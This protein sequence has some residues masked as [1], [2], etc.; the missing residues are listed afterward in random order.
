MGKGPG[1]FSDI[2]KKAKDLLTKDYNYDQKLCITTSTSS[3]LAFTTTAIRKGEPFLGDINTKFKNKNVTTE[4]K[5]DTSSNIIGTVTIDEAAPGLKT[6]VNFTIPDQRT[7]KVELQYVHDYTGV[8]SSIGLTPSPIVDFSGVA[9]SAELAAGGEVGFDTAK[10]L[11]TKYNAGLIFSKPDFTSAL[12]LTDKGDTVKASYVHT[13]NPLTNSTVG[14]EMSHSFSRNE[15]TFTVGGLYMLDPLTTVKARL[16]NR[17][18]LAGLIQH[19]WRPKS[20]VTISGE[21]DSRALDQSA[22]LGFSLALS[23]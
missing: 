5:V 3:G 10:G 19:E 12:M 11:F 22:K 6:I 4:F 18:M 23:P 17:G 14:A 1:L 9:G 15:N 2:G 8:S 13:L 20:V 21:V 7:G 16:N